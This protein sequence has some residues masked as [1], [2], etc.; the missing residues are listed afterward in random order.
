MYENVTVHDPN[1]QLLVTVAR[2]LE[3]LLDEIVFVGGSVTGLLITD[4]ASVGIRP[5]TDVDVIAEV[6]SYVEYDALSGRLRELGLLED[7][8]EGA[9]TCR[10]C[11]GDSTVDVMPVDE[12]VLGFANRWYQPAVDSAV[13]IDLAEFTLRHITPVYFIATKLEAFHG[14]GDGDYLASHDLED[15][16]AVVDGREELVDE[17]LHAPQDVQGYIREE[18]A[19]LLGTE[20]FVDALPGFLVPDESGQARLQVLQQRL[21]ALARRRC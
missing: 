8:R 13:R 6:Y 15:V 17:V 2:L 1:L 10:W 18:F 16:V 20:D 11:H 3:P 4:E 12:Q 14:R 19:K 7:N 5:T 9:P 21:E